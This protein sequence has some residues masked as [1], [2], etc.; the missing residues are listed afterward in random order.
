MDTTN[1]KGVPR[2]GTPSK[3]PRSKNNRLGRFNQGQFKLI[4]RFNQGQFKLKHALWRMAYSTEDA[5]Q[6]HAAAGH[7][8]RQAGCCIALSFFRLIGGCGV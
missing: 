7:L 2:N 1:N 5:R 3:T 6:D 4:G 8:W